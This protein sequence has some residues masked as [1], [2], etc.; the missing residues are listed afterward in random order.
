MSTPKP[1]PRGF[2]TDRSPLVR[3]QA[4]KDFFLYHKRY[5]NA[6]ESE[7]APREGNPLTQMVDW[8]NCGLARMYPQWETTLFEFVKNRPRKLAN[9]IK[10]ALGPEGPSAADIKS[11]CE[12]RYPTD[13]L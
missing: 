1:A 11:K 12:T 4:D 9:L 2:Y 7:L 6:N 5:P 8:S 13:E 3:T 10:G